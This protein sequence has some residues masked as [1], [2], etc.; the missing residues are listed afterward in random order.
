MHRG[1]E[2][3]RVEVTSNIL[4][5][6]ETFD[7]VQIGDWKLDADTGLVNVKETYLADFSQEVL[8]SAVPYQC[9]ARY[10]LIE[11]VSHTTLQ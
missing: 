11:D 10:D 3:L 8:K 4:S 7:P 1:P 5:D 2:I 6:L 9:C